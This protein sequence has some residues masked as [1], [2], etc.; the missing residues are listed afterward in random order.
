MEHI[1]KKEWVKPELIM[2]SFIETSET[3]LK[4]SAQQ[5]PQ[6]GSNSGS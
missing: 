3:V 2:I 6:D 5:V 1:Q 4:F